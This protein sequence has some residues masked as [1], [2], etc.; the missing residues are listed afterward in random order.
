MN[1]GE[2]LG[3]AR[4]AL[5]Q[6]SDSPA[7]DARRLVA[8]AIG[9]STAWVLG[10]PEVRLDDPQAVWLDQAVARCGAGEPLA[11]VLGWWEFYGR[12]FHVSPA[13]L[14][15]RP[16]TE[17]L[18]ERVLGYLR[19]HPQAREVAD[20]GTGSGCVAVTLASEAPDVRIL[21]V[22]VSRSALEVAR[23]NARA[24]GVDGRIRW[25]QSDLLTSFRATWDVIV[26]NLPYIPN[27]RLAHLEVARYE[28][29]VALDGGQDGLETV[30]RLA[31]GL[32]GRLRPGGLAALEIDEGQGETL[33]LLLRSGF[34]AA[35]VRV[36]P[37][38][39]GLERYVMVTNVDAR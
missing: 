8:E 7:G 16:E 29:L 25:V 6:S 27:P 37:D 20:V 34:A 11:Y 17:S 9:R 13:V 18:V 28:P 5:A 33:R 35:E 14:I 12:R 24:H 4:R 3:R 36:E 32:A 39:S 38:L 22:D 26:A 15:P 31:D 2:A 1:V 10:H 30:R 21:A 19:S 23:A